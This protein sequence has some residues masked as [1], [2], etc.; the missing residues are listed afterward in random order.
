M[1]LALD[2]QSI[3]PVR[4]SACPAGSGSPRPPREAAYKLAPLHPAI[5]VQEGPKRA[6]LE[7]S[8]A[9]VPTLCFYC[10]L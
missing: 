6:R 10:S 3:Y 8:G 1:P 7:Q 9:H 5:Q 4:D 2:V